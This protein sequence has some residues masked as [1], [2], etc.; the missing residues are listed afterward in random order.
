MQ[1]RRHR[2]DRRFGDRGGRL[3]RR[4]SRRT[5]PAR[6]QVAR[7]WACWSGGRLLLLGRGRLRGR[8]F[9]RGRVPSV[10]AGFCAS[11][12]GA[13]LG[14][15][16]SACRRPSGA[17]SAAAGRLLRSGAPSP[18]ADRRAMPARRLRGRP[19]ATSAS[20]GRRS[21]TRV[22]R[23]GGRD[24]R[25]D[26]R[27]N[28]AA[29]FAPST[30]RGFDVGLRRCRLAGFSAATVVSASSSVSRVAFGHHDGGLGEDRERLGALHRHVGRDRG[31]ARLL[32]DR[33]GRLAILGLPRVRGKP[34]AWSEFISAGAS[35]RFASS[36]ARRVPV[37]AAVVGATGFVALGAAGRSGRS[38]RS[39]RSVRSARR[40]AGRGAS[41]VSSRVS[42]ASFGLAGGRLAT[43]SRLGRMRPQGDRIRHD[44]WQGSSLI[45]RE[46]RPVLQAA[47][48]APVG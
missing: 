26:R 17:A 20:S 39:G 30:T 22:D 38:A 24:R 40:R 44:F 33:V 23:R 18:P 19:A 47:G 9:G 27:R 31:F 16:L 35:E 13:G 4:R 29:R 3:A 43:G 2:L 37:R 41:A 28:V 11:C 6:R 42:N 36:P 34:R 5:S 48:H 14:L 21:R 45:R 1:L 46:D 12:V 32:R 8:R 7:L 25:C 15:R 10:W